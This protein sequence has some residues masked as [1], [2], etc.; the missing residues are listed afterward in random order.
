MTEIKGQG[1]KLGLGWVLENGAT[2]GQ[3]TLALAGLCI[4]AHP[5]LCRLVYAAPH[6]PYWKCGHGHGQIVQFCLVHPGGS[7]AEV[8]TYLV[9]NGGGKIGL[10]CC[11]F[12]AKSYLT[13]CDSMDHSPPGFSVYGISQTRIREWVAISFSTGSSGPRHQTRIS[14][15]GWRILYH[16]T[17]EAPRWE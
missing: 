10:H 15:I 14:C 17:R 12:I 8:C 2:E 9:Q 5:S 6:S 4:L 3:S 13:L 7:L 11:C 16:F 1:C